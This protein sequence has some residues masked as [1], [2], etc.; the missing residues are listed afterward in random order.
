ML[1]STP[2]VL[3]LGSLVPTAA[4]ICIT[5]WRYCSTL[6]FEMGSPLAACTPEHMP[7]VNIFSLGIGYLIPWRSVGMYNQVHKTSYWIYTVFSFLSM[8]LER[9]VVTALCAASYTDNALRRM[10]IGAATKF[11]DAWKSSWSDVGTTIQADALGRT[12]RLPLYCLPLQSGRLKNVFLFFCLSMIFF[13]RVDQRRWT[14]WRWPYWPILI[15]R[16]VYFDEYVIQ[17]FH[18]WCKNILVKR[19]MPI[20]W[21]HS[22]WSPL[23]GSSLWEIFFLD[24]LPLG[25]ST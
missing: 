24:L 22:W 12:P 19:H 17:G 15:F 9:P 23:R 1:L 14:N 3:Y 20:D 5:E 13:T 10:S 7:S 11:W 8:E 16:V 25:A 2:M 4:N 21:G 6:H 18:Q